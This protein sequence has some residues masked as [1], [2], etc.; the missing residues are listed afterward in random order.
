MNLKD[1]FAELRRRN[2]YKVAIAYA[3][4]AC[5]LIAKMIFKELA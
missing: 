4:V 3:I 5:L 2:V 1:F